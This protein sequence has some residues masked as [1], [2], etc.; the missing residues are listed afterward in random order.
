MPNYQ[1]RLSPVDSFF[2][3]GEKHN[4]ELKTDYFVESQLYP[5]QTALL[6]LFRYYLLQKNPSVFSDS[7]ISDPK[8]AAKLIGE[9]SFNY[10]DRN[11]FG[12]I[13][14]ITPLY[15]LH[16]T[17]PYFFAPFDMGFELSP[18]LLLQINGKNYNAKDHGSKCS[19]LELY[20]GD[21]TNIKTLA[22]L[23]RQVI[24]TG[25]EKVANGL[26][27]EE[28]FYRQVT[29]QFVS[30][31][32]SFAFDVSLDEGSGVAVESVFIP[33]G[34]EKSIFKMTVSSIDKL[35]YPQYPLLLHQ[36]HVGTIICHSDC[37]IDWQAL[38]GCDF[39]VNDFTGFRNFQATTATEKI[40]TLQKKASDINKGQVRSKRY[41]LLKRG[42]TLYFTDRD[43]FGKAC[44]LIEE[45]PAHN[46]G[47][48]NITAKF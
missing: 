24:K 23:F 25:N 3:G 48:N 21:Q 2:F 29:Y 43:L 12:K 46:I 4:A 40:Y 28:A 5:Q 44:K 31:D 8:N 14:S 47:F 6:G 1:I 45:N 16:K 17:E 9:K 42:S 13:K 26:D 18:E 15:F 33:F 11:D 27:K 38:T 10:P 30:T 34:G 32:W 19:Q 22:Q 37:F 36:R 35:N 41:N 39:A 20:S 7:K